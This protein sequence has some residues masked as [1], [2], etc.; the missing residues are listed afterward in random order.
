MCTYNSG[1]EK[2]IGQEF[3]ASDSVEHLEA[4][5]LNALVVVYVGPLT[6]RDRVHGLNV[7]PLDV[8]DGLHHVDLAV[9]LLRLPVEGGHMSA[10]APEQQVPA[11]ARVV[12]AIRAEVVQVQI[13]VLLRAEYVH[14]FDDVVLGDRLL[15]IV[16][17]QVA[18][19]CPS[20]R[21]NRSKKSNQS[22]STNNVFACAFVVRE[23]PSLLQGNIVEHK[24]EVLLAAQVQVFDRLLG[25]GSLLW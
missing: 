5:E 9:Q 12:E 18:V 6:L 2:V 21:Q 11:C 15:F 24:I 7:Q 20:Q 1:E 4:V 16:L 19:K 25:V 22:D 13:E 3:E 17:L 10:R 14:L 8:V 23:I